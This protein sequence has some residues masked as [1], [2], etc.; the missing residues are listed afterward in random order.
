MNVYLNNKKIFNLVIIFLFTLSFLSNIFAYSNSLDNK[1]KRSLIKVKNQIDVVKYEGLNTNR[2][3]DLYFVAKQM[4]LEKTKDYDKIFAKIDEIKALSK[5]ALR[6]YDQ[7]KLLKK[8]INDA[9]TQI[10]VNKVLPI[11]LEAKKELED[12]RYERAMD[13]IQEANTK[14]GELKSFGVRAKTISLALQKGFILFFKT[15]KY[16][17]LAIILI[18]LLLY[19]VFRKY[20]LRY[21]IK[22]KMRYLEFKKQ[23]LFDL[24]KKTQKTYFMTN[25]M[26]E[27]TF[28]I[29]IKQYNKFLEDINRQIAIENEELVK[30][31]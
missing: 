11:Y 1:V 19:L 10:D 2:L 9:N 13:K 7:L 21:F 22:R 20:I 3:N 4:S 29:K 27:T 24:I 26:S 14:I 28:K 12:E 15:Y 25:N 16:I 17:I 5:T 23:V 31:K 30:I 8:N 6:V 18:P